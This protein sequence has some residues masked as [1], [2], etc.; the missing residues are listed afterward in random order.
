MDRVLELVL[1][2]I[3]TLLIWAHL[4]VNIRELKKEVRKGNKDQQEIK[5]RLHWV[6]YRQKKNPLVTLKKK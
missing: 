4:L 1:L 3:L 5:T 2:S 6:K